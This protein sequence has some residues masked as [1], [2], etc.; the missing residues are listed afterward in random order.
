MFQLNCYLLR[1]I[2]VKNESK[3]EQRSKKL[4]IFFK[5]HLCVKKRLLMIQPNLHLCSAVLFV[6]QIH[7]GQRP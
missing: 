1:K 5:F 4:Y 7:P 3:M 6:L 2:S